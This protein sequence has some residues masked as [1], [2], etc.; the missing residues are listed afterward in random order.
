MRKTIPQGN[1][2]IICQLSRDGAPLSKRITI[3]AGLANPI[4][5]KYKLSHVAPSY[6]FNAREGGV[7]FHQI[8]TSGRFHELNYSYETRKGLQR[9]LKCRR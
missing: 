2:F 7:V 4:K 8:L 6:T 5:T 3:S 9:S 1:N